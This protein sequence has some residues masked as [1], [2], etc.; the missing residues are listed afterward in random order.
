MNAS[1]NQQNQHNIT[2]NPTN[3]FHIKLKKE[4]HKQSKSRNLQLKSSI[5]SKKSKEKQEEL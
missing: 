4:I 5:N 1:I 3:N 2:T